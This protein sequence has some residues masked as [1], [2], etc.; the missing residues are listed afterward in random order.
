MTKLN[1]GRK[2]LGSYGRMGIL[3]VAIGVL[4]AI[5]SFSRMNI[6][7]KLWPMLCTVSGIGFI[8]IYQQRARREAAYIVVG[9]FLI[10][11][12]LLALYC[13]FTTWSALALFWPFFIGM[14]GVS[15]ILGFIFGKRSPAMFLSGLL[16]LSA[17]TVFFLVFGLDP[18]LWWSIFFLAGG[19]FFVFDKSRRTR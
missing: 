4:L 7:Y 10:Q 18:G 8:G 17:G 2:V 15:M 9:S 3:L 11:F 6:M 5:D 1:G 12:S 13:N 14:F 19:S 16:T